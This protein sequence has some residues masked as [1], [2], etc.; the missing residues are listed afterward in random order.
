MNLLLFFLA[1]TKAT[2]ATD[3]VSVSSLPH[4]IS[5]FAIGVLLVLVI[6]LFLE[7][8]RMRKII[9]ELKKDNDNSI[10]DLKGEL[11][12]SFIEL[13]GDIQRNKIEELENIKSFDIKINEISKK[14]DSRVDKA[15]L[16]IKKANIESPRHHH[17][18]KR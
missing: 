10:L 6:F 18:D 5:M 12:K 17:Q 8:N 4:P 15:I 13:K 16:A 3:Y 7:Y 2:D 1:Q 11:I 14:V 9:S